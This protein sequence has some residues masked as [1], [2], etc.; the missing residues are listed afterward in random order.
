MLSYLLQTVGFIDKAPVN[1]RRS[2]L[3][4]HQTERSQKIVNIDLCIYIGPLRLQSEFVFER[5]AGEA[6]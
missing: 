5:N 6:I 1:L 4:F 3:F 2:V